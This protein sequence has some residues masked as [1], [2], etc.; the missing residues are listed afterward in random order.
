MSKALTVNGDSL[1]F[2]IIKLYLCTTKSSNN[3]DRTPDFPIK[4]GSVLPKFIDLCTRE[5]LI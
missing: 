4:F 2:S 3:R 1:A 5:Y